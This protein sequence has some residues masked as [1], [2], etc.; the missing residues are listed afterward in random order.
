MSPRT[1]TLPPTD[2]NMWRRLV[3]RTHPDAGGDHDPFDRRHYNAYI[4]VWRDEAGDHYERVLFWHPALWWDI[5]R[6][7]SLWRGMRLRAVR[8]F[9]RN[10]RRFLW[11]EDEGEGGL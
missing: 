1:P 9:W 5:F 10:R 2:R 3:A 7:G 11:S 8:S 6:P 4:G